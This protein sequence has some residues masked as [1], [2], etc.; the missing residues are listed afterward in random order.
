MKPVAGR[1]VAGFRAGVMEREPAAGTGVPGDG[2]GLELPFR[3]LDQELLERVDA[4]DVRDLES[5]RR[6]VRAR[7]LH[8]EV[9]P[10]SGEPGAAGPVIELDGLEISQ[11]IRAGRW[12]ERP[13]VVRALPGGEGGGVAIAADFGTCEVVVCGFGGRKAFRG[14]GEQEHG[15]EEAT[16]PGPGEAQVV[17]GPHTHLVLQYRRCGEDRSKMASLPS[18]ANS[19]GEN[20]NPRPLDAAGGPGG[21]RRVGEAFR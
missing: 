8:V 4:D 14:A 12:G 20:C 16:G 10:V 5:V 21:Q 2:E 17:G 15:H 7:H 13:F 3:S 1:C 19:S 6:A 18:H 9:L 11:D